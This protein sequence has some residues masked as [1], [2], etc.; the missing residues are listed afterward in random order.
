MGTSP[1]QKERMAIRQR[2]FLDAYQ[3]YGTITAAGKHASVAR[4]EHYRW[5]KDDP[6]Y[7]AAFREADEAAIELLETEARRRAMAGD[8]YSVLYRG[9]AISTRRRFS[10]GLLMFLLKAKRPEV[11]RERQVADG[12]TSA[13]TNNDAQARLLTQLSDDTLKRVYVDLA[14]A[15]VDAP[16]ETSRGANASGTPSAPRDTTRG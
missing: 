10:D 6:E 9:Q 16:P 12:S 13:P 1:A 3:T 8:E 7:A 5:M 2:A 11:Y 15:V 4:S 14:R